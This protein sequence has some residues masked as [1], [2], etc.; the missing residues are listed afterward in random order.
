MKSNSLGHIFG[1]IEVTLDGV[2]HHIVQLLAVIS[3]RENAMS[4]RM[5][6]EATVRLLFDN[7]RQFF[8]IDTSKT[9]YPFKTSISP[10]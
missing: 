8:H 9:F 1:P 4:D 6:D 3:L 7:E 2:A 10:L 5:G